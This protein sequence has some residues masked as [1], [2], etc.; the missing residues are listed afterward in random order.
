MKQTRR[1]F[2]ELRYSLVGFYAFVWGATTVAITYENA[3]EPGSWD[4]TFALIIGAF[5]PL[6]LPIIQNPKW[7]GL[8]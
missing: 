8:L 5:W 6:W 3:V 1:T 4:A 2:Y 7:P